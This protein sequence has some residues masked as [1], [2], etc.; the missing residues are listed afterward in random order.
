MCHAAMLQ[1]MD[2]TDGDS[3]LSCA[4]DPAARL[5]S[6]QKNPTEHLPETP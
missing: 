5:T 4:L 2:T 3:T 1:M 6:L